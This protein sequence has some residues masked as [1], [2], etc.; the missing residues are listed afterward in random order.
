LNALKVVAAAA[1]NFA[2]IVTFIASGRIMWHYCLVSMVFAGLGGY[3][4]AKYTKK[5]NP[6]VLRAVVVIIGVVIAGYF[7]W[8]NG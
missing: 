4:G 3:I 2:A 6:A 1:S 8:R 5:L 7:F